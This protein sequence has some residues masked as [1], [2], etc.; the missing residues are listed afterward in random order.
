MLPVHIEFSFIF[1]HNKTFVN[2]LQL[3]LEYVQK[4]GFAHPLFIREKSSLHMTM[5]DSTFSISD[6]SVSLLLL[7]T[8]APSANYCRL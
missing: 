4:Q 7:H 2:F 6:V 8:E 5:P 1:K 3:T